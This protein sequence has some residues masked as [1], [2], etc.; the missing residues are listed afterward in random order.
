MGEGSASVYVVDD[1]EPVRTAL[2]T[3]LQSS[4]LITVPYASAQDFLAAYSP[5]RPGC[6]LLDVRMPGMSGLEMQLEL[7][8]RG[9]TIP[10]IFMSGHAD[11]PIAV[12]AMQ[13]GAFDFVQKPF[14]HDQLLERVRR[15]LAR[16]EETREH[17]RHVD[18]IRGRFARL[19]AREREILHSMMQGKS[20]KV[21]A[22]DLG[23]S[24]RTVEIHRA[25]VMDKMHARSLAELVR[26]GIEI[27]LGEEV[28]ARS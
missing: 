28:S 4:G 9:A 13:Q 12:E 16:D 6:L 18:I 10:V 7:N 2:C 15:A 23:V 24:Q 5:R 17:L 21:M 26:M 14:R 11:V 27:D 22:L 20:N 3:V 8:R 19:T 1:D 25:R